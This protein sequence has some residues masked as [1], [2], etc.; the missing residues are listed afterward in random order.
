M[1]NNTRKQMENKE[2][3]A[4][5]AETSEEKK[6]YKNASNYVVNETVTLSPEETP[7]IYAQVGI[8]FTVDFYGRRTEKEYKDIM[9]ENLQINSGVLFEHIEFLSHLHEELD[10]ELEKLMPVLGVLGQI[11]RGFVN[12]QEIVEMDYK[13]EQ[14]K[15]QNKGEKSND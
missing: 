8:P 15:Y 14:E 9:L 7:R 5:T 6:E 4:Q 13:R 3:K 2:M 11:G 10:I 1:K 12:A